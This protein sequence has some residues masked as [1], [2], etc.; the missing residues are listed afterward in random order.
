MKK[1]IL[2]LL[3]VSLCSSGSLMAVRQGI[4]QPLLPVSD[5]RRVV[6]AGDRISLPIA[7]QQSCAIAKKIQSLCNSI[8]HSKVGRAYSTIKNNWAFKSI[9]QVALVLTAYSIILVKIPE[10]EALVLALELVAC[11]VAH[12][13]HPVPFWI[14]APLLTVG[15]YYAGLNI[16]LKQLLSGGQPPFLSAVA[17]I[18][19]FEFI[20]S[21]DAPPFLE[22][23]K[24]IWDRRVG[25]T[26]HDLHITEHNQKD[27]IK[28]M[29]KLQEVHQR[30]LMKFGKRLGL[31][32]DNVSD[33]ESA[34]SAQTLP[35]AAGVPGV[36]VESMAPATSA[37]DDGSGVGP[38]T[39][40][41]GLTPE[42]QIQPAA[43][44]SADFDPSVRKAPTL[45]LE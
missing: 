19:G 36:L 25:K 35:A 1:P 29:H 10:T 28:E 21:I 23:L 30:L 27:V 37:D 12:H 5:S 45:D 9:M 8:M 14:K 18:M 26:H 11:L 2:F 22:K 33:L 34:L 20:K 6:P 24:E 3:A 16:D 41:P 31:D 38:A 32:A 42:R 40:Q 43:A 4:E 15:G 39:A 17:L 13:L 44:R 7:G